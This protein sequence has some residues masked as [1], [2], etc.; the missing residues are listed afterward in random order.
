MFVHD[1]VAVPSPVDD[2]VRAF[3]A[4]VTETTLADMVRTA[5]NNDAPI[6]A[7]S[8]VASLPDVSVTAV[9]VELGGH[10]LRHDAAIVSLRW[11]GDGW[12]PTLDADVEVVAFGH[13]CTHLHLMG[14]YELPR[15]VDRSS[16]AGSLVQRLMD[17]VVR[18]F[19]CDVR[20][21]LTPQT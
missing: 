5:W 9:E 10:R 2:M 18:R 12:L 20:E 8:G 14:R 4:D 7:A 19:L 16:P 3:S 21:L 1:F 13:A 11:T 6:L 15:S 17:V